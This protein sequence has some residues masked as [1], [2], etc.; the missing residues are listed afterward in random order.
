M[1]KLHILSGKALDTGRVHL[2]YN[3]KIL[4]PIFTREGIRVMQV[5]SSTSSLSCEMNRGVCLLSN[6]L[7]E[8]KEIGGLHVTKCHHWNVQ[9]PKQNSEVA[10]LLHPFAALQKVT[11]F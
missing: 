7:K 8:K 3:K 6:R 9:L 4:I 5:A 10:S 2:N 11:E 1:Q